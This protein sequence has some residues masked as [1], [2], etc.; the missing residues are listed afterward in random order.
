MF[1]E[2]KCALEHAS[3]DA[4]SLGMASVFR[5]KP[6]QPVN[7]HHR[8]KR[9]SNQLCLYCSRFVGEGSDI[10]SDKEHLVGKKFV[11]QG[12]LDGGT[13]FNFIFRACERCNGEKSE[14]EDHISSVTL[15]TSSARGGD[16]GVHA[17]ARHKA[18]NSYHPSKPGVSVAE[19]GEQIELG[20]GPYTFGF[21]SPPQPSERYRNRLALRHIQGLFSLLTSED[22][23]SVDGTRLLPPDQCWI[24]DYFQETDWGNPQ[25][26]EVI[27][28]AADWPCFA[29]VCTAD[30]YFR[31][32][33]KREAPGKEWF[34][35]LE[36]NKSARMC[37]AICLPGNPPPLLQCLPELDWKPVPPNE[38]NVR[39]Y[40]KEAPLP[41]GQDTLFD[42]CVE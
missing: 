17:I 16:E 10:P 41:A 37:G 29:N 11:P 14:F 9:K 6:N 19:S 30:G 22:P 4:K 26:L 27:S 5:I 40:R 7:W 23:T 38:Q 1:A 33:I 36:W 24:L 12:A 28:R 32:I 13:K 15:I 3:K 34:W 35:A 39:R 31:A 42:A 21:A 8:N 18:D 20:G 2:G 25:L